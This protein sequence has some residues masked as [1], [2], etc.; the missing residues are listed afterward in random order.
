MRLLHC[1]RPHFRASSVSEPNTPLNEFLAPRYWPVWIGIA[2]MRASAMLPFGLLVGLGRL[3]GV[4]LRQGFRVRRGIAYRNIERCFPELDE[5]AHRALVERHFASLGIGVFETALAWWAGTARLAKRARFEGLEHLER[6]LARG[7]GV[8][9]LS[10]HFTTMDLGGRLLSTR[11]DYD[12]LYRPLGHPLFDEIM[13]RGRLRSARRLL[14][15]EDLRGMLAS[16]REGRAVWFAPD[17]AHSGA[18]SVIAPFFSHPAPTNAVASRLA[19]KTGAAVV[20]F[21]P[22]RE[23]GNRA[24][25]LLILPALENFPSDRPEVDAARINALIEHEVRRFPEQYLWIHRR[26]KS[27]PEG[28]HDFYA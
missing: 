14:A 16:L 6:A 18:N 7:R 21:F 27:Q 1:A 12:A 20:P 10:A 28:G 25:R 9:L 15:K 8:I 3:L 24:Y 19:G 23:P 11:V 26:F 13:R 22:L 4:V 2:A 5:R 17:Q